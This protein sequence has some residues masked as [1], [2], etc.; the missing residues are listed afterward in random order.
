[1]ILG[2][3]LWCGHN[4]VYQSSG[5]PPADCEVDW[6]GLYDRPN[7]SR[8]FALIDSPLVFGQFCPA[9]PPHPLGQYSVH[10]LV[11]NIEQP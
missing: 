11:R 8:S 1:M 10:Q 4:L 6:V 7:V 9:A 5:D 3:C 2:Q